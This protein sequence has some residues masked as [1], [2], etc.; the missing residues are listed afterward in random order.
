MKWQSFIFTIDH[1]IYKKNKNKK[2]LLLF[3]NSDFDP[4]SHLLVLERQ[5]S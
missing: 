4:L 2:P 3:K 5:K 1:E